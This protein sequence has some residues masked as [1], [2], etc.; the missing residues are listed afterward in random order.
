M[1]IER[2]V[3]PIDLVCDTWWDNIWTW[4]CEL[5][6]YKFNKTCN[7]LIDWNN[8]CVCVCV[9][10][11]M[12]ECIYVNFHFYFLQARIAANPSSSASC[13]EFWGLVEWCA[14]DIWA[15]QAILH[16]NRSR[17][18]GNHDQAKQVFAWSRSKRPPLHTQG[19]KSHKA[20]GTL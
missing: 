7:C 8:V 1:T 3:I 14:N 15:A 12:I 5:S 2:N 13:E 20:I 18:E 19:I 10:G 6:K 9:F 11:G 17:L 16:Y 4:V